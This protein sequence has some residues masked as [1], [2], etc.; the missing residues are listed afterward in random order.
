M[1][2]SRL[3]VAVEGGEDYVPAKVRQQRNRERREDGDDVRRSGGPGGPGGRFS[4]NDRGG[5]AGANAA[6]PLREIEH[7][8]L[9]MQLSA[10]A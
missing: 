3:A 9:A 8:L 4:D 2:N 10:V 6:P 1:A 5:C 7:W